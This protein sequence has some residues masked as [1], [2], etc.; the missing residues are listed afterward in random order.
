MGS[1]LSFAVSNVIIRNLKSFYPQNNFFVFDEFIFTIF[2]LVNKLF[3]K[4]TLKQ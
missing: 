2:V 1:K 3:S 4:K